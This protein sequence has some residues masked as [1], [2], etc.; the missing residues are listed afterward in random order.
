MTDE[1]RKSVFA[2]Q[3]AMLW[4]LSLTEKDVKT[5]IAQVQGDIRRA[6]KAE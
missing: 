5:T 2:K 1:E 3:D 6:L 4:I